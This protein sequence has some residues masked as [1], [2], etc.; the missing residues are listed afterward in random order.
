MYSVSDW[1]S[2]FLSLTLWGNRL[3]DFFD[4]FWLFRFSRIKKTLWH[5]EILFLTCCFQKL[6]KPLVTLVAADLF[7]AAMSKPLVTLS[8]AALL[9]ADMSRPLV[10]L[11]ADVSLFLDISRP[12]VT[13]AS[14]SFVTKFV[15]DSLS[16]D[17]HTPLTNSNFLSGRLRHLNC[18][19]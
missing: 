2:S 12:L 1:P 4:I 18:S 19:L 7:S 5:F 8:A 10:N 9:S 14:L 15:L 6:S 11:P 17:T 3:N 16:Q 13:F